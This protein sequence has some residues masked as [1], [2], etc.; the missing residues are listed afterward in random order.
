MGRRKI[1]GNAMM[2]AVMVMIMVMMNF[3]RDNDEE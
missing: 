3:N 2:K 1:R